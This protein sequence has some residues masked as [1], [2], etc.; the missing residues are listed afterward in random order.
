VEKVKDSHEF[1]PAFF[2]QIILQQNFHLF[3]IKV[4]IVKNDHSRLA[5]TLRPKFGET[6]IAA[7]RGFGYFNI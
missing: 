2:D 6:Q 7:L 4:E 5:L 1:V 3:S